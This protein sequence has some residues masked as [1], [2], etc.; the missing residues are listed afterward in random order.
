MKKI[1]F[2]INSLESGGAERVM[3]ILAN[4]FVNLNYEV[5]II[6][7]VPKKPFYKLDQRIKLIYPTNR[8]SYK[9]KITTFSDRLL[10][11][12]SI[13][14]ILKN[15]KPDLVVPFSTTTNGTIIP[16]CKILG[17]K[18]V[19]CE[20]NNYKVNLNSPLIWFIKR[21]IY[22]KTDIL[23]VLTNRD[24]EQFYS[25][26]L[27]NV[28]VMP[29]PLA[30]VPRKSN[31]NDSKE[32]TILAIGNLNRW[33]H[34]GFDN[35]IRIFKRIS[36]EHPD[37]K[38]KIAG[39]GQQ[40]Y[41]LKLITE[42]ELTERVFLLGEIENIAQ[43]MQNASIFVLTSR[44][45]GLPMVLIEAMSQGMACIAFDCFTGPADIIDNNI[46][47]ILVEDQ[48]I[49]E[50]INKLSLLIENDDI[51]KNLAI[52]AVEKSK[53]YLPERIMDKWHELLTRV[54]D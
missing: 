6:S 21:Y 4:E 38:L 5:S 30:L 49:D 51:R 33:K 44:W 14:K 53:E 40:E 54:I 29:N 12:Y 18:V 24:V 1:I 26:F 46:D 8:I 48:N 17:L 36:L 11:Y 37:W 13:Y 47:G 35:L 43:V 52:K 28:F 42:N 22:K 20:H 41:L 32:N 7:K 39:A 9:S 27:K 19:A 10:V 34:K 15:N 16:I 31:D 2:V 50:F 3:S 45:E 25:H 23:T